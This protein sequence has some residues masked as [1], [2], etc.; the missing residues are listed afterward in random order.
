[1]T[2]R[3]T[4]GIERQNQ[5]MGRNAVGSNIVCRRSADPVTERPLHALEIEATH[6]V[7]VSVQ[8]KARFTGPELRDSLLAVDGR[9]R[10]MY[11]KVCR[12]LSCGSGDC[13]R[14]PTRGTAV[15]VTHVPARDL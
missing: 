13:L 8:C 1:V 12:L 14:D 15:L 6:T 10:Q 2:L 5:F 3:Y 7:V 11:A 9:H 4:A